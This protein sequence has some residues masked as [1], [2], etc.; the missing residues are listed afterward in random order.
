MNLNL[1]ESLIVFLSSLD[2]VF[3]C[4]ST[5][6]VSELRK[7]RR[8]FPEKEETLLKRRTCNPVIFLPTLNESHY[9]SSYG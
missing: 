6:H 8:I 4:M 9:S 1:L 3:Y 5:T 2:I 7:T